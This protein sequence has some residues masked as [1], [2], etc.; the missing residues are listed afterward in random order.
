MVFKIMSF[1]NDY[2]SDYDEDGY[3][4]YDESPLFTGN[5]EKEIERECDECGDKFK[6]NK[7][8]PLSYCSKD[9][10]EEQYK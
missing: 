3:P 6:T 7:E 4:V 1:P 10:E 2:P 9:C 8:H 5:V